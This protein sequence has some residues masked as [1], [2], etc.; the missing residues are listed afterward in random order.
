MS[1]TL[2]W[3]KATRLLAVNRLKRLREGNPVFA[4]RDG[5]KVNLTEEDIIATQRRLDQTEELKRRIEKR[6]KNA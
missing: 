5:N 4:I 6:R 2:L 1:A 3:A